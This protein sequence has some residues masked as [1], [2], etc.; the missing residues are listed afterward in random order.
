[1]VYFLATNII[2][3]TLFKA[4]VGRTTIIIAHRLSTVRNADVIIV[5][6]KGKVVEQGK[7][8]ELMLKKGIYYQLVTI[9]SIAEKEVEKVANPNL[10]EEELGNRQ[11]YYRYDHMK[12]STQ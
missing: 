12:I 8:D 9:Q 4:S 5:V 1:M 7:H 6:K 2:C 11:L 10:T 3:G